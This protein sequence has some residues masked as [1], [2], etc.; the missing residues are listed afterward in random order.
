MTFLTITTDLLRDNADA[1]GDAL[2]EAGA[3]S[4]SVEDALEGTVDEIPIFGEPGADT[5]LW[6]RCRLSAMFTA[7]A[8]VAAIIAGACGALAIQVPAYEVAQVDD[9][10]WVQKNRDQFQPIKIS[11]R[12]W[13]VPSWHAAPHADAINI[14]LDPGAAFGTGSHPTTRLCLQWLEANL[15]P[16]SGA[17]MLDYGC[18][19]GILAIAAMKLGAATAIGVDIDSQA[20]DA[21]R[22]NASQNN[23]AIEFA[24]TDRPLVAVTD[25]TVRVE[26]PEKWDT[27][28]VAVS[29]TASA[30]A[31]K[32][33][34]LA[35]LF[36]STEAPEAFV[37]KFRGWE[38]LNE[39]ASLTDVGAVNGSIFLLTHRRRQPVR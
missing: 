5:G 14:V 7:P 21:A 3:L 38:V 4:V 13:I 15:Q 20:V 33:S 1:F 31:M 9:V 18:G 2:M 30:R 8:D 17:S 34:A 32:A 39:D 28:K 36:P 11:E 22:F 29:P 6:D 35:S 26:M 12:V 10:D 24:T 23:V 37:L 19:S 25:I 27:V 16:T